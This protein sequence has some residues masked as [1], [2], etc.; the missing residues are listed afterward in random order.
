MRGQ[1]KK[2]ITMKA[3]EENPRHNQ[4]PAKM[5]FPGN[6]DRLVGLSCNA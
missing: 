3:R 2:H 1:T 4:Q 5:P 6:A